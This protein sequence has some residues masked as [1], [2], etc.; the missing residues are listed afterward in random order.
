[1]NGEVKMRNGHEDDVRRVEKEKGWK[2]RDSNPLAESC[3]Q[4]E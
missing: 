1:M 4:N 3:C 2:G